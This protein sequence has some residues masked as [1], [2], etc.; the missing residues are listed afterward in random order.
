MIK[1]DGVVKNM[2]L[3]FKFDEMIQH[4]KLKGDLMN[5]NVLLVMQAVIVQSEVEFNAA[6]S[7]LTKTLEKANQRRYEA[8]R[9]IYHCQDDHF[10]E[11]SLQ[12]TDDPRL[13]VPS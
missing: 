5:L 3:N 10:L 4:F 1:E 12:L 9:N 2:I 7:Q 13:L 8:I 6:H 11:K